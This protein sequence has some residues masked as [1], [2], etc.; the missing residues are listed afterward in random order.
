MAEPDTD[1][2]SAHRHPGRAEAP[3]RRQSYNFS[4]NFNVLSYGTY[5][6]IALMLGDERTVE[7]WTG[8]AHRLG[9]GTME[10]ISNFR[11]KAQALNEVP[12]MLLL[13][14]WS[15]KPGATIQV[16]V[17]ALTE[18]ER[19]DVLKI[20]ED[21]MEDQFTL[22]YVVV[23][24][25]GHR[26]PV[27]R[28][29]VF[30]CD[31]L[32]ASLQ[33]SLEQTGLHTDDLVIQE[34]DVEAYT[35]V[36]WS[37]PSRLV[38]GRQLVLRHKDCPP[39]PAAQHTDVLTPGSPGLPPWPPGAAPVFP[40]SPEELYGNSWSSLDNI[41]VISEDVEWEGLDDL[42]TCSLPGWHPHLPDR[43]K[44][45][46]EAMAPYIA[47]DG[48][49]LI[50]PLDDNRVAVSVTFNGDM[51][52][53][54]IHRTSDDRYYFHRKQW[55]AQSINDLINIYSVEGLPTSES[56]K[57]QKPPRTPQPADEP[58][59]LPP[60]PGQAE[61]PEVPKRDSMVYLKHPVPVNRELEER[62]KAKQTKHVYQN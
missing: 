2:I 62:I 32:E 46:R 27:Q 14:E 11:V 23:T 16:I 31:T 57:V 21:A 5:R 53:F 15:R 44:Y 48:W 51:R 20:V 29:Q 19:P 45:I 13:E 10:D 35:L 60:R 7:N 59:P 41:S 42:S 30:G 38:K 47:A 17:D 50:R 49:F 18:M 39:P 34:P 36:R 37:S 4:D 25:E 55:R 54:K 26:L 28:V 8:L 6:K 40:G 56:R 61:P 1:L 24:A 22:H 58:P 52:H 9:S 12:A 3:Q 33:T 43:Q